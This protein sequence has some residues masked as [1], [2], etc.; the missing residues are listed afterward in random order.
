MDFM[1]DRLH[2]GERFRLLTLVDNF[3]RESLAID[4]SMSLD[5]WAYFNGVKLDLS[6]PGKP[7]DNP[8]IES[9]N[10]RLREE[11]LNQYWFSS[12]D[13]ARRLT[14]AWRDDSNRHRPHRALENRTP[15][16]FANFSQGACP[17]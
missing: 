3:S 5:L 6:R 4:I 1:S 11:C 12:L 13:E 8:F 7:T 2:S 10:G 14:E 17:L 9:F 16:E 15:I